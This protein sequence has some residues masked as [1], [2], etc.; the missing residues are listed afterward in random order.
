MAGHETVIVDLGNSLLKGMKEG[1]PSSAVI[2]PHS[3]KRVTAEKFRETQSR[4]KKGLGRGVAG[5]R[6][7]FGY[8]DSHYVIGEMAEKMGAD[9]RRSGGAKYTKDYYAP[10]L[11]AVLL[12]L[13][14]NGYDGTLAV[15]AAFP[16]G[17][18]RHVDTLQASLGGKHVVTLDNGQTLTFKVKKVYTYDEPVGGL[19]NYL[20]TSDGEHYRKG[21]ATGYGLCVDIGAKISN[22]VPF[23][24]DGRVSYERAVSV[25]LGIHDVMQQVSDILLAT[26]DYADYFRS[27]RGSLPFD[28]DMRNALKYGQYPCGGYEL[29]ALGAV[30]DATTNLRM[31]IKQVYEQQLGGARAY[32]FIVI[33]GGGG[34]L[35]FSQMVEHVL[36][37]APDRV[38]PAADNLDMMHLANLFGGDK[39]WAAMQ[40][41]GGK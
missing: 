38:Y 29:D 1:I 33:T 40:A 2:V 17:D 32:K 39:A 8:G 27:Q 31:Q 21:V 41:Q 13:Y 4:I 35:M 9:T 16:P 19:W 10:L 34:G 20:L 25:D 36:N 12:H 24:S 28:D 6:D 3:L 18:I 7:L 30:A 15:W 23:Y 11:I 14:P 5:S 26:P 37:F 22:L